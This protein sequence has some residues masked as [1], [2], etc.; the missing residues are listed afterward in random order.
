VSDAIY[1]Y[2]GVPQ[3]SHLGPILFNIFINDIV[4]IFR[5]VEV[6]LFADDLKL[7][8]SIKS[9]EDCD[10]LQNNLHSLNSWCKKNK[11][12]LNIAKCQVIRFHRTRTQNFYN[13]KIDGIVLE[14][15]SNLRD[16]GITFSEDLTFNLHIEEIV[17][18]AMR[19]LGFV[20]RLVSDLRLIRS[21]R[22]LF[23]SLVRPLLEYN[24]AVWSPS[25][26][27][28][29]NSIER[30]QRK[31]LRLVNYRLGIP[32]ENINYS[33]LM[34]ELKLPS[35]ENR[36]KVFDLC[37]LHKLVNGGINSP[38]LLDLIKFNIPTRSTRQ[39]L[40]FRESYT[41]NNYT[42]HSPIVRLHRLGNL[43]GN[44]T[45]I[46]ADSLPTFKYDVT[47]YFCL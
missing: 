18:K 19:T 25:Y 22:L 6:L 38:E 5:D 41:R 15:V 1:A 3:G 39:T 8:K 2:S 47:N 24:S 27:V 33:A 26:A 44:D 17:G 7:Y 37:L 11:L 4:E 43:V 42:F 29:V 40:L 35:L 31:F 9:T 30:V 14:C 12:H 21:Y 32:A 16:L 45:D 23:V 28:H 13:Y 20:F 46:F 10:V 34:N 36:R